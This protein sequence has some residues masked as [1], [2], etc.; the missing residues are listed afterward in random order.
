MPEENN[1]TNALQKWQDRLQKNRSEYLKELQLMTK[2]TH[3][4]TALGRLQ[5]LTAN[6]QKRVIMSVM[7]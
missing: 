1:N 6:Q 7:R 3:Y 4:I 2:E 5:A